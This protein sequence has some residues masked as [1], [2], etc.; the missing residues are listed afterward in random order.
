MLQT[1]IASNKAL[2]EEANSLRG[3][4]GEIKLKSSLDSQRLDNDLKA[5][6]TGVEQL[7]ADN[8]RLD[9]SLATEVST[10]S[11]LRLSLRQSEKLV[12]EAASQK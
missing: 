9:A 2:H 5:A 3:Q 1:S 8:R 7:D 4:L 10:T 6:N 11:I 12:S